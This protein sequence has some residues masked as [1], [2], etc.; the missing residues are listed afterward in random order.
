MADP[1]LAIFN[2][3]PRLPPELRLKVWKE[4]AVAYTRV[5][6]KNMWIGGP[7]DPEDNGEDWDGLGFNVL[8]SLSQSW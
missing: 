3:S 2:L 5:A 7:W 1:D 4:A 8:P 6:T